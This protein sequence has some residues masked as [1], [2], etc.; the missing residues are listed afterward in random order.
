[1]ATPLPSDGEM[2]K[3][4][5]AMGEILTETLGAPPEFGTIMGG[6]GLAFLRIMESDCQC[7]GCVSIRGSYAGMELALGNQG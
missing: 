6:I 5:Q 7:D 2:I 3:A 4:S 1:M